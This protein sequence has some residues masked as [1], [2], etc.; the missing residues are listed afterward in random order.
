MNREKGTDRF[1]S[2]VLKG[3][4]QYQDAQVSAFDIDSASF[5]KKK[6]KMLAENVSKEYWQSELEKEVSSEMI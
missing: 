1:I 3:L 4:I 6:K 2:K 5:E